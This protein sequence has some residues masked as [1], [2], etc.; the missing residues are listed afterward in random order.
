L[1]SAAKPGPEVRQ[2]FG[3]RRENVAAVA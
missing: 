1:F 3:T 2:L